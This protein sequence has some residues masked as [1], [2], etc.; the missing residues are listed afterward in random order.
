MSNLNNIY[1]GVSVK[2]ATIYVWG[3]LVCSECTKSVIQ[4]G[5]KRVVITCP[6]LAPKKWQI[7]W[8]DMSKPMYDEAGVSI[9]YMNRGQQ[10]SC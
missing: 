2:D 9:T 7:Q 10:R 1:N 3:L 6:E 4:S 5:I 8:K